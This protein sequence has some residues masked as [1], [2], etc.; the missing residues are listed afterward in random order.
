MVKIST[1]VSSHKRKKRVLKAAKGQF[2]QRSKRYQQ[3][4]ISV[5]RGMAYA[6]KDRKANKQNY[7][8]LWTVRINAACR[9]LGM[10]YSR[11]IAGLKKANITL[12]RKALA[13]LAIN[14][15]V[16]FKK[17]VKLAGGPAN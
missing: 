10:A 16:A 15:P 11:F 4:K 3:A 6:F 2:Q 12:D 8:H 14:S 7:R 5:T 9:E 13:E 17:L 1:A